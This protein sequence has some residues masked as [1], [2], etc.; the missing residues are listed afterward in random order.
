MFFFKY[1]YENPWRILHSN[2]ASLIKKDIIWSDLRYEQALDP[3]NLDKECYVMLFTL[4]VS[5]NAGPS[6]LIFH[7]L[8]LVI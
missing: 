6:N 4:L 5:K 1:L 8:S 7:F 3:F 2:I